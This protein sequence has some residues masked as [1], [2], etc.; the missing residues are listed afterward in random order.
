[1]DRSVGFSFV[2]TV[3]EAH[4]LSG[5]ARL[6]GSFAE[7]KPGPLNPFHSTAEEQQKITAILVPRGGVNSGIMSALRLGT[8]K[9]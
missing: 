5:S 7:R 8:G 9:C 1:M 4:W 2:N 3:A 6:P